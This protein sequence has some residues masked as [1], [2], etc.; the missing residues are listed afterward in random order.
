MIVNTYLSNNSFVL[1]TDSTCPF[2]YHTMKFLDILEIEYENIALDGFGNKQLIQNYL[3]QLCDNEVAARYPPI[4]FVKHE[5]NGNDKENSNGIYIV[6]ADGISNAWQTN[7]LHEFYPEILSVNEQDE[8]YV[9]G[10]WDIN[11]HKSL[12]SIQTFMTSSF[13]YKSFSSSSY[14]SQHEQH[15]DTIKKWSK[16]VGIPILAKDVG[17]PMRPT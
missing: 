9:N 8:R 12:T 5:N 1:F 16:Y 13:G 15:P 17:N 7:K 3:Q 10:E 14:L 11:K 4:A 6:G 2:S